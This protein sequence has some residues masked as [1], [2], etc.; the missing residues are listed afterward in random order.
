[1]NTKSTV[2]ISV[3]AVV[4][5]VAALLVYGG[6]RGT[7]AL[8]ASK[9]LEGVWTVS[10]SPPGQ[11]TSTAVTVF[12]S[13]GSVTIM[14][15]D[16]RPGIGV[17]EKVSGRSYAFTAWEYWKEGESFFQAKVSGPIEL[18][19]GG[20]A[21]SGPFSLQVFVVGNSNPIVEGS[22]TATGVRMHGK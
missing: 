15:N 8:A 22:G 11:P 6:I 3:L 16:G 20:E 10:V 12:H 17:W 9:S 21:Y 4:M 14:E 13:D 7:S 5:L 2:R 19:E 1:V 18:S